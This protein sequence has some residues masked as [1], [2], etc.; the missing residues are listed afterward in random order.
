[1]IH[2]ATDG[3]T[4]GHH[5][6]FGERALAYLLEVKVPKRGFHLVNFG[7]FLVDHPP[8]Y[9]VRLNEGEDGEGTS[10]SCAHG[11]KRWKEHCGC[12]AG[13]PPG[14]KQH[15]RKPLRK[16]LDWLRDELAVI[17]QMYGS[18][19]LKNVWRARNDYIDLILDQS[20]EAKWHF[21]ARHAK[22]V[23]SDQEVAFCL[24]LLEMQKYAMLMYT[25]CGWF[26]N[27]ISGIETIQILQYAAR[28]IELTR[29]ATE[30][31]LEEEFLYY[32]SKARSN[33]REFKDGRGV[34]EKL[35]KPASLAARR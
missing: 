1:M 24:K 14:W 19:Y 6:A 26:F 31:S 30:T 4:F 25:S 3:E 13:G 16:T 18:H 29:E 34:Y 5:K 35:V 9:A 2:V 12:Q 27:D 21:F 15:W 22:Q 7:E 10:W 11:V 17:Y 23:L 20:D 8:R 28:A 32:L 33:V